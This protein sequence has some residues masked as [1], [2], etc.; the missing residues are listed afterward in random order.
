MQTYKVNRLPEYPEIKVSVPGSKSMTNR[1]LLLAA[2]AEGQSTLSGVLF[3]DD[4]NVFLQALKDLGFSLKINEKDKK[5]AIQGMG[6]RVPR[7]QANIYVGSAGTAARFI[8]SM[9]AMTSGEFRLD[10]SEQMKK[11]PMSELL[12]ALQSLGTEITYLVREGTFPFQIKGMGYR[13]ERA[14]VSVNIDRSSQFLSALLMTA[15][16]HFDDLRIHLTGNRSA[17]SYVRMTEQMMKQFGHKG[18]IQESERCFRVLSQKGYQAQN[19]TIE[20]DV[21]AACYFYAMAA[22]TGGS[23]CVENMREDSL[24]GDMKFLTVLEKMGCRISK[25]NGEIILHGAQ[26]G[27]LKGIEIDMSD[28]SDQTLTLAAIAPYAAGPVTIRNVGHIRGQECD[29]IHAITENLARMKIRCEERKDGV[30]IYPGTPQPARIETFR[31]HR[32]AMAFAVTGVR[33]DGIV[34]DNPVCCRK[35]FEHYFE[36]LDS[37]YPRTQGLTN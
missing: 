10:A 25:E 27:K 26:P 37:L 5:V 30:T 3:S 15:P 4:S 12:D 24:Q 2:L 8:T 31:D 19:Y 32:V 7:S 28:F 34:I 35:T 9:V 36:V 29:R 16:S 13:Q 1:A 18:V 22:I 23:C 11:R 33:T 14:E 17:L 21:S 20:P 6:G